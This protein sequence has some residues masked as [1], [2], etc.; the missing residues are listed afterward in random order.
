MNYID[1]QLSLSSDAMSFCYRIENSVQFGVLQGDETFLTKIKKIAKEPFEQLSQL[2]G[3]GAV[4]T[5]DLDTRKYTLISRGCEA[6][7]VGN[8]T[9]SHLV[10]P[11]DQ[12]ETVFGTLN[13]R[14]T[15]ILSTGKRILDER[16]SPRSV[17]P[18]D[19]DLMEELVRDLYGPFTFD[20]LPFKL[21]FE[22]EELM[23]DLSSYISPLFERG[24]IGSVRLCLS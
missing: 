4:C 8:P 19:Y 23:K 14:D 24:A 2:N 18:T 15:L 17:I 6:F 1:S 7:C 11:S 13:P 16:A 5:L 10:E 22:K 3:K 12:L 20:N 21:V 9:L